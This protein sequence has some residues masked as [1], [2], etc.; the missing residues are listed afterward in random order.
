MSQP[1]VLEGTWEEILS[2][3]TAELTGHYVRIYI[4]PETPATETLEAAMSRLN[5]RT[6]D[7]IA[8]AR[9]RI[10]AATPEP[11]SLPNGKTLAD[12]IVGKWPGDETDEE[13]KEALR[14]LL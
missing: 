1:L 12:M 13:I 8:V 9:H 2:R 14:K 10:M 11:Q 7:Q 5:S 4:D 3:N 6:P